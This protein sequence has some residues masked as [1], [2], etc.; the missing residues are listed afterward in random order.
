MA[1]QGQQGMV[2]GLRLWW[3]DTNQHALGFEAWIRRRVRDG[4]SYQMIADELEER[5]GGR[6]AVSKSTIMRWLRSMEG[7]DD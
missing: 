2:V 4:Y 5:T 3:K 6:I 7:P 1:A